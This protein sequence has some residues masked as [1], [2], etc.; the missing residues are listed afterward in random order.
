MPC[1]AMWFTEELISI[2]SQA[3]RGVWG[4]SSP[5]RVVSCLV[6]HRISAPASLTSVWTRACLRPASQGHSAVCIAL[7]SPRGCVWRMIV[8]GGSD[9]GIRTARH[10]E[11]AMREGQRGG[12]ISGT[13]SGHRWPAT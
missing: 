6:V 8:D 5:P 1:L 10:P 3:V 2:E 7:Q 12:K 4:S 11:T 9:G 13:V